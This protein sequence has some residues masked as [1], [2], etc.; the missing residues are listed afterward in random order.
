MSDK[1]MVLDVESTL[2]FACWLSMSGRGA[3]M[4][5]PLE[6][7]HCIYLMSYLSKCCV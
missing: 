6:A 1:Q 7:S 3:M 4:R 2:E 5:V